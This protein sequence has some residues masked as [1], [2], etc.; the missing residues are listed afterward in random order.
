MKSCTRAKIKYI[1]YAIIQEFSGV[2]IFKQLNLLDIQPHKPVS[3]C[4]SRFN[5][6]CNIIIIITYS[7]Y[8]TKICNNLTT[9]LCLKDLLCFDIGLYWFKSL[10]CFLISRFKPIFVW[11]LLWN[12]KIKTAFVLTGFSSKNMEYSIKK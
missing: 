5:I 2:Q 7:T 11:Y 12:F 1:I 10:A 4:G 6:I 3:F 9:L 8:I